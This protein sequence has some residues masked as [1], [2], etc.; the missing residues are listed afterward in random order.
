[1]KHVN[2]CSQKKANLDKI[3]KRRASTIKAVWEGITLFGLWGWRSCPY[4]TLT[5]T[6]EWTVSSTENV[7]SWKFKH[8]LRWKP[9]FIFKMEKLIFSRQETK[10]IRK[11]FCPGPR[12]PKHRSPQM[13]QQ[14]GCSYHP[15]RVV[16]IKT[17]SLEERD[18]RRKSSGIQPKV[19]K[20]HQEATEKKH[21][22]PFI[23]GSLGPP[24]IHH[25]LNLL[26]DRFCSAGGVC[27]PPC[28]QNRWRL[29]NK[30]RSFQKLVDMSENA[31]KSGGW[32][33]RWVYTLQKA[34]HVF[35]GRL[36]R[37]FWF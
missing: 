35:S 1:M 33:C 12:V 30:T 8:I 31:W 13:W 27:P 10:G 16:S 18:A 32:A 25:D 14:V 23:L 9:H 4:S 11:G 34:W 36:F 28:P 17:P 15:V 24:W 3:Q 21:I 19:P 29:N 22:T 2:T 37:H 26:K 20:R 7:V 5:P 6:H